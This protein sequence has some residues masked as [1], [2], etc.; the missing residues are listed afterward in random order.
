MEHI[1]LSVQVRMAIKN[2]GLSRYRVAKETGMSQSMMSRFMSGHTGLSMEY[3]DRLGGVL[4]LAIVA[5]DEPVDAANNKAPA[6]PGF[7]EIIPA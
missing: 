5:V 3:L 4:G 7:G 1:P 6:P 2:S